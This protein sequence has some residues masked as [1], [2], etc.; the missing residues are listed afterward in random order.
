M[1]SKKPVINDAEARDAFRVQQALGF[2]F[3]AVEHDF[4]DAHPADAAFGDGES[5]FLD[6]LKRIERDANKTL[7]ML[8]D[9]NRLL[10]DY[11][12]RLNQKIDL[13][14]RYSLF[15]HD[16]EHALVQVSLSESGISFPYHAALNAGGLVAMRLIFMPDY[17]PVTVYARVMRS[18]PENKTY[19]IAAEF[20]KLCD[21]DRQELARQ[22]FKA[23]VRNRQKHEPEDL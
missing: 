14:V 3:R 5:P 21:K 19:Q 22:V 8:T 7:K 10:G 4:A 16:R 18:L 13:L 2:E 9:K 11:L 6:Q 23:Q 15:H 17:L 20:Y 1:P 12:Q